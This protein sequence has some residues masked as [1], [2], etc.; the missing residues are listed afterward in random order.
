M[1]SYRDFKQ[2][3]DDEHNW[4]TDYMFKFVSPKRKAPEVRALFSK[5]SVTEKKSR[6]GNYI[7]F[8]FKKVIYSSDEVVD[9]YER[10]KRIEGLISL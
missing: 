6:A 4:P 7:S 10:A 3:L 1:D 5:E 9:I 2:Q 8:T